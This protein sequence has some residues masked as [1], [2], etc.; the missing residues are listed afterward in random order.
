MHIMLLQKGIGC[1]E[2]NAV[3]VWYVVSL[4]IC[5]SV[6]NIGGLWSHRLEFFGKKIKLQ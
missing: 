3:F 4:S 5:L 2:Q 1:T 6:C